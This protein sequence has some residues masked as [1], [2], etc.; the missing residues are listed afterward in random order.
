MIKALSYVGVASPAAADWRTFGP[1]IL[2]LEDASRAGEDV[3]RMRMDEQ[4]WRIA[5]HPGQANALAYAGWEVADQAAMTAVQ[6]T[7]ESQ[8]V[9]VHAGDQALAD[10]RDAGAVSWFED[11]AGFRHE[12]CWGRQTGSAPFVSPHGINFVTGD[13]GLGHMVLM[14]PDLQQ[15]SDFFLGTL[16]FRHSD[17]VE[18]GMTIRFLH[19]NPR[20]HTLAFTQAPGHRG[21]HHLMLEVATLDDM[22]YA[23]DR[24]LAAGHTMAMA[25]GKHPNDL[26]TSFYVRTPSGFEVEFGTGGRLLDMD[27]A[28]PVGHYTQTSLWGHQPPEQPLVPGMIERLPA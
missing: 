28:E 22:G 19:C 3:V 26:M 4:T 18:A 6:Q 8:G 27:D 25:I 20:H 16:G 24:A 9:A 10:E 15:A 23:Y 21:M 12:I 2:G 1:D 14:V 13:N 17:D 11:P 5:I 7:L